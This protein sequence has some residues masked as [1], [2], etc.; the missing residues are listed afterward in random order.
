MIYTSERLFLERVGFIDFSVGKF[1]TAGDELVSLDDLSVMQLDL[2]VPGRYLSQISKGMSVSATTSA[3]GKQEFQ[4][5]IVGVDSR[6]NQETPQFKGAS[7][8]TVIPMGNL[9]QEC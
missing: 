1:V 9:S 5:Q 6:I 4:G 2:Q 7:S 3:W 8:L